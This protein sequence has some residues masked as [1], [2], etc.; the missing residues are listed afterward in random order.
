MMH[1]GWYWHTKKQHKPKALCSQFTEINSFDLFKNQECYELVKASQ[2]R[3]SFEIP[4]YKLTAKLMDD[5]SLSVTYNAG[6]YVIFLSIRNRVAM[7]DLIAS[8]IVL[9]AIKE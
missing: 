4:R 5:D 6:S 9:S 2:D 8:F 7:V 1:W 3:I